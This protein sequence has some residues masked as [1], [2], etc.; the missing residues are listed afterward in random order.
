MATT[1][2]RP[3][4]SMSSVR[5]RWGLRQEGTANW[6]RPEESE[7]HLARFAV[8]AVAPRLCIASRLW[9]GGTPPA[10]RPQAR[11]NDGT[12]ATPQLKGRVV[13]RAE[14]SCR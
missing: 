6:M 9:T 5:V 4:G 11:A 12:L 13:A 1:Y 10:R 3:R 8:D 14:R 7:Q 2:E